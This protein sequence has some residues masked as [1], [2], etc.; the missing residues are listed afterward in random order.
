MDA[1]SPDSKRLRTDPAVASEELEIG[2]ITQ[3]A[4]QEQEDEAVGHALTYPCGP[5]EH[6]LK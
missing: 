1:S 5:L 6:L 3:V 2:K 4:A